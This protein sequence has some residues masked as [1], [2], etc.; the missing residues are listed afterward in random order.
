MTTPDPN[1]AARGTAAGLAALAASLAAGAPACV[2]VAPSIK[3]RTVKKSSAVLFSVSP[4]TIDWSNF[5]PVAA[6]REPP[7]LAVCVTNVD[8]LPWSRSKSG[9]YNI[10]VNVSPSRDAW[11]VVNHT[12]AAATA[13]AAQG[14]SGKV[15]LTG[16]WLL[17]HERLHFRIAVQI[18][19][20]LARDIGAL[21]FFADKTAA[22][23]DV[24]RQLT[25]AHTA[26]LAKLALINKA[27]DAP[28]R[29]GGADHGL[30]PGAQLIW[31]DRV[32]RWEC[33]NSVT[34]P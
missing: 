21:P 14:V 26:A 22:P 32:T 23:A 6:S 19:R 34:W 2:A 24:D 7:L 16:D 17:E 10:R 12:A 1:A 11:A 4:A 20:D 15:G 5:T 27:Y 13:A 29:S 31:V 28:G 30:L 3:G 25:D 8:M 9:I 33:A 18:G